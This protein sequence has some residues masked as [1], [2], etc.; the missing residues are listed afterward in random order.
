[1]KT[2][3]GRVI[4]GL[5]VAWAVG[6][7]AVSASFLWTPQG[8]LGLNADYGGAIT[9]VDPGSPAAR[10]GIVPGDRIDLPN[11]P[12][13]SRPKLVGI[14][15]PIPVGTAVPFQIRR[16]AGTREVRLVAVKLEAGVPQ[17]ISMI[18]S[19]VS[20]GI[21]IVVGTFLIWLRP[22][23][24]TWGFGLFC[25]LINPVV[26]AF[27]RFPSATA[28]LVYVSVYDII[29]NLG[30]V[31]LIVF[32][33]N[34]PRPYRGRLRAGIHACLAPLFVLLAA[35]TLWI[36]LA[37]NV[38]AIP[39][40]RT[41]FVL[42][43]AFGGVDLLAIFLLTSTYLTGPRE[44]RPRLR[45]VLVGFYVG[46]VCN[47]LGTVLS[48]TASA[49][50]PV[51]LDNALIATEVTLP[52]AVAYAVVKHRVIEIDFFFSR[53]LVYAILTTVLVGLFAVSDW[54]FGRVLENF[55]LSIVT[56]ALISIAAAFSFD[57]AQDF[58]GSLVDSVVFRQRQLALDRIGRT[59]KT[60]SV[61]SSPATIDATLAREPHEALNVSTVALF[62]KDGNGYRRVTSAG[63]G[64]AHC[65]LLDRDDRLVVTHLSGD[66]ILHLPEIGWQR[67]DLPSGLTSPVVSIPL[68][69]AT[70]LTGFLLCS[71][72]P[73]GEQLDPEELRLLTEF[74]KSGAIAYDLLDTEQLR[75]Q[76]FDL[77]AQV[78][79]LEARLQ[80]ARRS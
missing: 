31:G 5:L 30:I 29:Q 69:S 2:T 52:L 66:G 67:D 56:D 34:F 50:T 46:L 80:E 72:K 13:E 27:S 35:W 45:W 58:L 36:D 1:M 8:T 55:R 23:A 49:S 59:A 33:L 32:A 7:L 79:M 47:Y 42:Q 68:R 17:R 6:S 9:S 78:A 3:L 77:E 48:Y 43:L 54:L 26:P 15:T 64:D 75:K 22:S 14:V 19:L 39:V 38:F 71:P 51:W 70:T 53:A 44:D 25:L 76:N 40:A 65:A 10:A 60:F 24:V 74:T 28:H 57:R 62:R 73:H 16:A 37:V 12:F 21:F 18:L 63:W 20:T 41:N 61:M 4:L 11:T